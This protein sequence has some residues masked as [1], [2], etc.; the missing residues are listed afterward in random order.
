MGDHP[1]RK[2]RAGVEMTDLIFSGPLKYVS[3]LFQQ[4]TLNFLLGCVE[5][6]VNDIGSTD[7]ERPAA[8]Y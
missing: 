1:S 8:V 7:K 4:A 5:Q 6:K 3:S 2:P